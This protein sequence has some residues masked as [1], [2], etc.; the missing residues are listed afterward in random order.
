MENGETG[1]QQTEIS[2]EALIDI[3]ESDSDFE[4]SKQMERSND[5]AVTDIKVEDLDSVLEASEQMERRGEDAVIDVGDP[6]LKL[7]TSLMN[8]LESLHPLS[9]K[10]I[11]HRVQEK[12]RQLDQKA[13]T[14]RIVSIGPIHHGKPMLRAM[15]EYKIRYLQKF[16]QRINQVGLKDFIK[17]IKKKETKVRNCY[18]EIIRI[19]SAA[20]VKLILMDAAFILEV[21][22]TETEEKFPIYDHVFNSPRKIFDVANDLFLLEN[23]LPFFILE[24]LFGLADIDIS[25]D[26]QEKPSI[27]KIIHQFIYRNWD[28]LGIEENLDESKYSGVKHL[29]E[30]LRI[31]VV[32]L[33]PQLKEIQKILTTPS[34]KELQQAG[35]KF[36]LGSSKN[37]FDIRFHNG[38]LEIPLITIRS[39]L[40]NLLKNLLAFEQ[41][42]CKEDLLNDYIIIMNYLVNTPKDVDILVQCQIIHNPV[43][44]CE[45]V[46]RLIHRLNQRPFF[47]SRFLYSSLVEELNEYCRRPSHRWKATLKQDYFKTPWTTVSVI[48][49]TILLILTV[50]LMHFKKDDPNSDRVYG[51]AKNDFD[52][53]GDLYKL[54]NQLPFFI[55]EDLFRLA[56]IGI[57]CAPKVKHSF[58]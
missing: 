31:S 10:C 38:I 18:A 11:I 5:D 26:N 8:E 36:K 40:E 17:V 43:G 13:Y 4:G 16:L 7:E 55:L 21:L 48:A 15:E 44:D 42:H 23:Q 57:S 9:E 49:A 39:P 28:Y 29:V 52:V 53:I 47:C 56:N 19:D 22:L 2:N 24:D 35:V 20:L 27:L 33:N 58:S 37:L 12:L 46:S 25:L 30:F 1:L 41:S 50:L 54:E 32:P 51:S 45:L 14:P 3:Q 34:V 6:Y